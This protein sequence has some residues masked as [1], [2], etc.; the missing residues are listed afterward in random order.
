MED[1]N[2]LK[3]VQKKTR[4]DLSKQD[5]PSSLQSLITDLKRKSRNRIPSE[6]SESLIKSLEEISEQS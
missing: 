6:S 1:F 5:Q 3:K 4:N 2:Q